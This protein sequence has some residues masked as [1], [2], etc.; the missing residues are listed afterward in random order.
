MI[1]EYAGFTLWSAFVIWFALVM[2]GPAQQPPPTARYECPPP[3]GITLHAE[4]SQMEVDRTGRVFCATRASTSIGGVV[5]TY[6]NGVPRILVSDDGRPEE[7]HGNGELT[8]W[9]DGYLRYITVRVGSLN[10]PR[11]GLAIVEHVVPE[12]TP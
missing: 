3:P 4:N 6:D 1:R 5:W 7:F 9:P 11:T 8:V 10:P 12:W 2:G